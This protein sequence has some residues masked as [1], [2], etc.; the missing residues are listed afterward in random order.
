MRA[1]LISA[2]VL[3]FAVRFTLSWFAENELRGAVAAEPTWATATVV[4]AAEV[5]EGVRRV[6]AKHGCALVEES[7]R[8]KVAAASGDPLKVAGNGVVMQS[9]S[10]TQA[11]D[12][13]F[14]CRRVGTFFFTKALAVEVH[15][16][17]L[18]GGP[19]DEYPKHQ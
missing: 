3:F 5:A 6:T 13:A 14:T 9:K 18:G 4:R 7:L 16:Q 11:I 19:A 12:I 10:S 15:T 17:G 8:V 1:F 2:L